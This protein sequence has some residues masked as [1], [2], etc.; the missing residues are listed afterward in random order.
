MGRPRNSLGD[1]R[2]LKI[3]FLRKSCGYDR[4][5]FC[6]RIG[7]SRTRWSQYS[8]ADEFDK[9]PIKTLKNIGD[10]LCTNIGELIM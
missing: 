8:N 4:D 7:I 3:E 1:K 10:L 6:K 9:M 5:E 2:W